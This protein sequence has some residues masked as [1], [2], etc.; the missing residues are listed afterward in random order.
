M[1]AIAAPE[2][3]IVSWEDLDRLVADLAQRLVGQHFDVMLAITRGGM[4][5]I[6][7]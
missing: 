5:S 7:T 2:R 1:T 4:R 6:A 3:D